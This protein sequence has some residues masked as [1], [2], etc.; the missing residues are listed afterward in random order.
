MQSPLGQM[1][2]QRGGLTV[3]HPSGD[4]SP[5]LLVP[6]V[7]AEANPAFAQAQPGNLVFVTSPNAQDPQNQ[8]VHVYRISMPLQPVP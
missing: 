7:V 8:H 1:C 2:L 3:V 4:Q 5:S 6:P